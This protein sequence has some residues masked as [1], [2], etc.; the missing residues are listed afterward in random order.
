MMTI[1]NDLNDTLTVA[2]AL[3]HIGMLGNLA[4]S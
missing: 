1:H 4:W 2:I 3:S